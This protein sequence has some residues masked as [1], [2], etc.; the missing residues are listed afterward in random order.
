MIYFKQGNLLDDQSEALVNTVNTVGVM[1]KGIALQ[2][3]QAY[4]NVFREYE[5][6]SKKGNVQI[7]QMHIVT[8]D[9][10]VAPDY[11]INFPT[12]KHWREKSKITYIEQGL[13]DLVRVVRELKIKSLALPPL[14]CGNGGLKW[15]EV[16]PL[17]ENAFIN[18]AIDVNVYEP[19]G[20]PKPDQMKV[21]T[22]KP[23][24]TKTRALLLASM[25]AYKAPGYRLSLL[26]V[27]KIAYFLQEAGE[28]LKLDFEKGKYGP[29]AENLN[30]VLQRL[31]GHFIRG[32]GDRNR[33]A[34]IDL[35]KDA[36]EKAR[37]YLSGDADSERRLD[38]VQQ[39]IFGSETPYGLE[40]LA[41]VHWVMKHSNPANNDDLIQD[42]QSW[43]ERKKELF[44]SKHIELAWDYLREVGV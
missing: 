21:G 11:V 17:I 31:E 43:N 37:E 16:K 7:G 15:S 32:Y 6:E 22:S 34:E 36:G 8:T 23:R 24:L 4:P 14:G 42:V 25:S 41:T 19:A 9:S 35:F 38:K 13:K 27:Q 28:P 20:S 3:K 39:V 29:Y 18:E 40:L 12:K 1:G 5:K 2:V 30:F 44:P 26:E 33:N 10:I